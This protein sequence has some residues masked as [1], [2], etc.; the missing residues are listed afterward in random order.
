[1]PKVNT[2]IPDDH[3]PPPDLTVDIPGY[4]QAAVDGLVS[5][6]ERSVMLQVKSITTLKCVGQYIPENR[7]R[8]SLGSTAGKQAWRSFSPVES[9]L[10]CWPF[11]RT[12]MS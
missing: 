9:I 10:Q 3:Y 8:V 6:L 7:Y 2:T 11:S 4:L 1:M 5:Q 12:G